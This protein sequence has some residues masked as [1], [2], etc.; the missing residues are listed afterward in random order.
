[1]HGL[2][3]LGPRAHRARQMEKQKQGA[4]AQG[5]HVHIRAAGPPCP[6][7]CPQALSQNAPPSSQCMRQHPGVRL[8]SL[9]ALILPPRP[10]PHL[11]S[12]QQRTEPSKPE[13]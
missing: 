5:L 13:L 7:R 1:M 3:G 12:C 4:P 10:R 6:S 11:L 8:K 2:A 9:P